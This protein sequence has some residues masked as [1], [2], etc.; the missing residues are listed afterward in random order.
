MHA[1]K[2]GGTGLEGEPIPWNQ[3]L[4][5]VAFTGHSHVEY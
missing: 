4:S 2:G 3:Q 1:D 5:G